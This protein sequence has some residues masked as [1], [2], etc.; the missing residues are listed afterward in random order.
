MIKELTSNLRAEGAQPWT[1]TLGRL[2]VL[3]GPSESGK[4]AVAQAAELVYRGHVGDAFGR[5]MSAD[6]FLKLLTPDGKMPFVRALLE[7]EALAY[8]R[9]DDWRR[10]TSVEVADALAKGTGGARDFFARLVPSAFSSWRGML[11]DSA[12]ATL[13]KRG[14]DAKPLDVVKSACEEGVKSARAALKQAEAVK[15]GIAPGDVAANFEELRAA[16]EAADQ[17]LAEARRNI[18]PAP[19]VRPDRR[20][21]EALAS[22][23]QRVQAAKQS[24]KAAEQEH[25]KVMAEAPATPNDDMGAWQDLIDAV[26]PWAESDACPV[27]ETALAGTVA[28]QLA[29]LHASLV[30][31]RAAQA[32]VVAWQKRLGPVEARR[33]QAALTAA[34]A[35]SALTVAMQLLKA[36]GGKE[37]CEARIVAAAE[38]E[39]AQ[40][41]ALA[42]LDSLVEAVTE[43][44]AALARAE[45]ATQQ[46]ARYKQAIN[47]VATQQQLLTSWEAL[48]AAVT[49]VQATLFTKV[50]QQLAAQVSTLMGLDGSGNP[51]DVAF[52]DTPLLAP[53][54]RR[55]GRQ[56]APSGFTQVRMEVALACLMAGEDDALVLAEDRQSTLPALLS[57]MA[58]LAKTAPLNVQV[59]VQTTV[60]MPAEGWPAGWTAVAPVRL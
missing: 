15:S 26:Q 27:C 17:A 13:T 16:A 47:N 52:I 23:Q 32:A 30:A 8:P 10:V 18:E 56:E 55:H 43:A 5:D 51:Y 57:W 46:Q 29:G 34:D 12:L 1:R 28:E 9:K 14:L 48:L 50:E 38:A 6:R 39:E 2:S 45:A 7:G 11:S 35:N 36:R 53:V 59:I 40:R 4:T 37:A 41:A 21:L 20:A 42:G 60:A 25:A 33:D 31:H 44:R 58:A 19:D 54:V 22:A 24:L 3:S 49:E